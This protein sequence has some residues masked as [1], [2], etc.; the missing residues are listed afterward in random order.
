[1]DIELLGQL[2]QRL[3]AP[4]GG[5]RYLGLEFRGVVATGSTGH[6]GSLDTA[7]IIAS[8]S[9][10]STYPAVQISGTTSYYLGWRLDAMP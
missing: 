10:K 7:I 9:R 4:D 5:Q 3:L 8:K 2:G 1:V 6:L